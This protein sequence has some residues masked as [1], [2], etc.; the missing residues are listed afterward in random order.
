MKA[1]GKASTKTSVELLSKET[2]VEELS[3]M[4]GGVNI[5]DATRAH[6]KELLG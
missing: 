1:Q 4:L 5:T 2:R 3:R 6:A